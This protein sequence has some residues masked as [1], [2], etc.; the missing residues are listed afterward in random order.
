MNW[1]L[2]ARFTNHKGTNVD[3]ENGVDG[4]TFLHVPWGSSDFSTSDDF[5]NQC[6]T[7]QRVQSFMFSVKSSD[8]S[9]I[10]ETGSITVDDNIFDGTSV[11]EQSYS[12]EKDAWVTTN[13]VQG[14]NARYASGAKCSWASANGQNVAVWVLRVAGN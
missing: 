1:K 7:I 6:P 13:I 10:F 3:S 9:L 8:G 5:G 14:H 2:C 4:N 11:G 12:N